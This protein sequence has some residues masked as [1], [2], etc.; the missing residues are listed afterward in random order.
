[1]ALTVQS[2]LLNIP[3]QA[4]PI[5]AAALD[6][7]GVI[8]AANHQFVRL[9]G[10]QNATFSGRRLADIVSKSNRPAVEAAL[11]GLTLLDND[12]QTRSIRAL[13]ATPPS[14]RLAIDVSR[15]GPESIAPYLACLQE[16]P[17]KPRPGSVAAAP[18]RGLKR[19]HD[20]TCAVP[21]TAMRKVKRWSPFLMTL[22]HEIRGPLSAIQNW[23]H[24][25]ESGVLP[26]DKLSRALTIIGRNA[27]S[28]SS[29]IE[30]MFDLSRQAVGSLVLNREVL[31]LNPL[32]RHVV[33]SSL[34]AARR[35]NVILSI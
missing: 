34:P 25:A 1:M 4:L 9:S 5:A 2:H 16:I 6:Q 17:R 15:L 20:G 32:T 28:L 24:V 14:L 35:R 33:E 11:S 8:V 26:P 10:Q 29:L 19:H 22:S 3:L 30:E 12:A 18:A 13:R 7:D 23:A 31:D 21:L 27:A